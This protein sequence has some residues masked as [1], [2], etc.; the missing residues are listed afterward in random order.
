MDHNVISSKLNLVDNH[1]IIYN[2][3]YHY[4]LLDSFGQSKTVEFCNED[5]INKFNNA[6]VGASR[7][8]ELF[9]NNLHTNQTLYRLRNI[10]EE[11][12]QQPGTFGELSFSHRNS[13]SPIP[14]R[15]SGSSANNTNNFN[16][17]I[18]KM[19]IINNEAS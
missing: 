4:F 18:N 5:Q 1:H 19:G 16:Q 11:I 10:D 13:C 3:F 17:S 8:K 15:L 7:R 12:P 6:L 9:K 14:Q 2:Y